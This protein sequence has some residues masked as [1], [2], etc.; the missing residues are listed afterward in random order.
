MSDYDKEKALH[1][2]LTKNS[3]YD[4]EA[5]KKAEESKF[6]D[7]PKGYEDSFN[8]YGILINGV[9]VYQSMPRL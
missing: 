5:L 3:K 8:P 4:E 7:M 6:M 1:D 2:Y 9:G